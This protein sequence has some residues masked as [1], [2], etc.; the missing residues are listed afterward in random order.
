M[1]VVPTGSKSVYLN[2]SQF[3]NLIDHLDLNLHLVANGP[4]QLFLHTDDS[5]L[6]HLETFNIAKSNGCIMNPLA[7][8]IHHGLQNT[9]QLVRD[10]LE[11]VQTVLRFFGSNY[12]FENL[13]ICLQVKN[14]TLQSLMSA[15]PDQLDY[16]VQASSNFTQPRLV[17][18]SN[19][20]SYILGE[21]AEL[22]AIESSLKDSIVH[23]NANFEKV[24]IFDSQVIESFSRLESDIAALANIEMS[25]QEQISD[26]TLFTR[27]QDIRLQYLLSRIQHESTLH[28]LLTESKLIKNLELLERSLFGTNICQLGLCE[29]NIS[30][31]QLGTRIRVHRELVQLVPVKVA[32]VSC[33]STKTSSVPRIHNTLADKTLNGNF[34][35]N[36]KIYSPESLLNTSL[37]NAELYPLSEQDILLGIFHHYSNNSQLYIQCLKEASFRLNDNKMDCSALEFFLL[38]NDFILMANEQTLRSQMLIQKGNEIKTAWMEG[39]VFSNVDKAPLPQVETFTFLHPSVEAFFYTPAGELHVE[40][41]SYVI[42]AITLILAIVFGCCCYRNLSFRRFFINKIS[43][44]GSFLYIK[45]TTESFRLKKESANLNRKIDKNWSDIEKMERLIERKAALQAKLPLLNEAPEGT[46]PS[47]PPQKKAQVQIHQ[48]SSQ[49]SLKQNPTTPRGK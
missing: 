17:R 45:M 20:L 4:P 42:T 16:C 31:E 9:M 47:A 43:S 35:V 8:N 24:K 28:R 38:P 26:L 36:N 32:L 14:V 25:L 10:I 21:G 40:H 34:L 15:S 39:F 49:V 41:T 33:M 5:G 44:L 48:S 22:S 7:G 18:R 11:K 37:V 13:G 12:L 6:L 2:V 23:F 1:F 19:I 46:Q 3:D 30:P 27:L 29:S